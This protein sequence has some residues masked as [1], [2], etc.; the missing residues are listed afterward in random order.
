[1]KTYFNTGPFNVV[2]T[3]SNVTLQSLPPDIASTV[4]ITHTYIKI[5]TLIKNN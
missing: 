4:M 1:M 2:P 3:T 5:T